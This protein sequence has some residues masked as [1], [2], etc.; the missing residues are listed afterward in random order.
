[1]VNGQPLTG[2]LTPDSSGTLTGTISIQYPNITPPTY[3]QL[4]IS[5]TPAN[6]DTLSLTPGG[7]HQRQQRHAHGR[8]LDHPGREHRD[9]PQHAP[10]TSSNRCSNR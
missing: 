6:G 4:P 8:D 2:T 5:G 1:M 9:R 3:W 10:R 7:S